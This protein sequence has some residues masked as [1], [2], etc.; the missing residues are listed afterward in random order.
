MTISAVVI[1]GNE[2]ANIADCLESVK[3]CDEIVVVDSMSAD[4]TPE[5]ARRYTDKVI[6]RPWPGYVAQKNF[7][8]EQGTGDW[9]FSI[10][11]DERC[12][13]ELK[14]AVERAVASADG[15]DGFRVKRR[16]RYLGR[17]INHGGWYPDWKLRVVRR[18]RA[19][20]TGVDPHDKLVADGPTR[21]LDA[22]LEHYT[23]RDFS[24]QL[25]TIDRFSDVVVEEWI[26]A[27][28]RPSLFKQ[29]FHPPVK[30]LECYLWKLGF[31]DGWPG[32]VIAKA[33]AFYVFTKQVKLR[34]RTKSALSSKL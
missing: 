32:F 15:V 2:E 14:A 11:A 29:L 25:K 4:R 13:P 24:H 30:F 9:L 34:E 33:S 20:W 7:A 10:D 6:R 8:L 17:W 22:D 31:L 19:R 26:K 27:G 21:D 3:W 1:C 16:V 28:R 23:Y 18:G 5:I 12:T